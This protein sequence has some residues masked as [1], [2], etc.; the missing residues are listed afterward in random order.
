M[1]INP[2]VLNTNPGGSHGGLAVMGWNQG[3]AK[4]GISKLANYHNIGNNKNADKVPNKKKQEQ[5]NKKYRRK[6]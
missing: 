6:F 3:D 4:S 5:P 1:N 2:C